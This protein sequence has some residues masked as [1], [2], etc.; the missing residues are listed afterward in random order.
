MLYNNFDFSCINYLEETDNHW[1]TE[2]DYYNALI[3]I[4][5]LVGKHI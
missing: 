4:K 3:K 5:K 2:E 1:D